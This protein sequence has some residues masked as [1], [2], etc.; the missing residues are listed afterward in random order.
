MQRV[1]A[2][3]QVEAAWREGQGRQLVGA[4]HELLEIYM[5][6]SAQRGA[7]LFEHICAGVDAKGRTHRRAL[8]ELLE[9]ETRPTSHIQHPWR[10]SLALVNTAERLKI[11]FGES[12]G[13]CA[14]SERAQSRVIAARLPARIVATHLAFIGL[15]A[16]GGPSA[17]PLQRHSGFRLRVD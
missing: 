13:M 8:K 7:C 10:T 9:E 1:R 11:N 17:V 2:R 14:C 16:L 6:I 5:W 4:H 12:L 15:A 3:Y